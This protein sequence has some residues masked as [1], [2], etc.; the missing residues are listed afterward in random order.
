MAAVELAPDTPTLLARAAG[1]DERAFGELY[2]R[3]QRAVAAVV[4]AK[5]ASPDDRADA[6]QETFVRAW[7][8]IATIEDPQRLL[9][10][11]YAIARNVCTDLQRASARRPSTSLDALELDEES[12]DLGPDGT[13][14]LSALVAAIGEVGALLSRRD[15]A[16]LSMVVNLG[17]GPPDVAVALGI[18]E[19]NARVVVHRA[20]RRLLR[21][22][23]LRGLP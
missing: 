9:P 7:R 10:W 19:N 13:A 14:E 1:G 17:F 4:A 15:A 23:A 18:T 3:H 6:V 22:L 11:L 8:R 20:R 5:L 21:E 2:R 16:V 12:A